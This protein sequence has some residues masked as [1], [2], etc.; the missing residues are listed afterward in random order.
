MPGVDHPYDIVTRQSRMLLCVIGAKHFED[1]APQTPTNSSSHSFSASPDPPV[2]PGPMNSPHV[3]EFE[4][5]TTSVM[6]DCY[7]RNTR[8]VHAEN[9]YL[10]LNNGKTLLMKIMRTGSRFSSPIATW[11]LAI[12]RAVRRVT[13]T[14]RQV[15]L[16]KFFAR[17][18]DW[19]R[20]NLTFETFMQK[21]FV[22]PAAVHA[23]ADMRPE[24]LRQLNDSHQ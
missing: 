16:T 11:Y 22:E 3:K 10:Q 7:P 9:H 5:Y 6:A 17:G 21:L 4:T 12:T 2:L 20:L 24:A 13:G 19:E 15:G 14:A 8:S 1:Y 18:D 23:D